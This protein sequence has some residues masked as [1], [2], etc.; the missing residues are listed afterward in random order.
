MQLFEYE[1]LEDS[2]TETPENDLRKMNE[3]KFGRPFEHPDSVIEWGMAYRIANGRSYRRSVGAVNFFLEKRGNPPISLSQFYH[4][5]QRLAETRMM[6]CDVTDARVL[7]YGACDVEPKNN[8][9]VAV[10]STGMSLNT[11]GGWLSYYWNMRAITGWVKLHV[12]IDTET[13]EILAYVIT[14]ES[15]GDVSCIEKLV[16]L[17]AGAGHTIKRILADAA[18]DKIE[19]WTKYWGA[20]IEFFANLRTSQLG[21]YAGGRV[22][23]NGCPF[24]A[25][26]I[27]IVAEKGRDAWKKLIGYGRRWK[28]ECTFSDLK[29]MFGDVMRARDRYKMASELYWKI[30][31]HNL[32]RSIRKVV[33]GGSKDV[34]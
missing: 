21:K 14:D 19:L 8:V 28:V 30:K 32:Y 26:Q 5:A 1:L 3:N 24:R 29:R 20:G 4:R 2:W 13:N 34:I 11:H 25:A 16:E 12:L 15:C 9:V 10:D 23:S 33:A 18:Y 6:T 7:G 22:K 31:C 27:R 17:A